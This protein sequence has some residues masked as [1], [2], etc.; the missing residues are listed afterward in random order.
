MSYLSSKTKQKRNFRRN[1]IPM[2]VGQQNFGWR[3]HAPTVDEPR[4]PADADTPTS[5]QTATKAYEMVQ[6][7]RSEQQKKK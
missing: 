7:R 6:T 5:A 4:P 1:E 2:I 3:K